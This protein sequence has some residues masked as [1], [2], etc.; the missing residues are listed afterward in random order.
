MLVEL[1]GLR[2]SSMANSLVILVDDVNLNEV[3]HLVREVFGL[4]AGAQTGL[5]DL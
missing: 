1:G 4:E 5:A 2:D 3:S